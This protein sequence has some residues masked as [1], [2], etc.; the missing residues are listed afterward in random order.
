VL[1]AYGVYLV[2]VTGELKKVLS[3]CSNGPKKKN[4]ILKVLI[5]LEAEINGAKENCPNDI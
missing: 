4:C 1:A 3:I 5:E 2:V